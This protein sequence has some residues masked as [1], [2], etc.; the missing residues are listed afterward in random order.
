MAEPPGEAFSYHRAVA[1]MMWAFVA[2]AAI[3][4]VVVHLLIS[5]WSRAAALVLSVLTLGS[6]GWLIGVIRSFRRLP[7][8]ITADTLV[9]RVGTLR[10]VTVPLAQVAGLRP[11]WDGAALKRRDVLNLALI[12]YPNVVI[13]LKAPLP[14]RRRIVAL[15]HRL[16]EPAAFGA[17]LA[18]ATGR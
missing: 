5:H 14:G 8:L 13:D 12:A 16:D 2:L 7:V 6:V 3:E 10:G 1:P 9:M 18:D 15:A 17:A 11:T 4:L